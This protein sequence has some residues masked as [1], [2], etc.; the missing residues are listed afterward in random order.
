M[1]VVKITYLYIKMCEWRYPKTVAFVQ[2][3]LVNAN[4]CNT[5]FLITQSWFLDPKHVF[6]IIFFLLT[7]SSVNTK[8]QTK[9][10][11]PRNF[12]LTSFHCNR[13]VQC[14]LNQRVRPSIYKIIWKGTLLCKKLT[15]LWIFWVDKRVHVTLPDVLSCCRFPISFCHLHDK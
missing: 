11:N 10:W 5:K 15:N 13:K 2:W 6:Y 9:I 1:E 7:Q 14:Q 8:L 3:K 12:V 4:T